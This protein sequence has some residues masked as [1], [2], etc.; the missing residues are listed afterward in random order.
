MKV[1]DM[2]NQIK[3]VLFKEKTPS[4]RPSRRRSKSKIERSTS[5][6][7]PALHL[8][9]HE[10]TP[11]SRLAVAA[12]PLAAGGPT[13]PRSPSQHRGET[14]VKKAKIKKS[15]VKKMEPR[16]R[17]HSKTTTQTI[18]DTLVGRTL[19]GNLCGA[20]LRALVRHLV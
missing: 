11:S 3:N 13:Q 1:N 18:F 4:N 12:A 8:G 15:C 19:F 20:L 10:R 9:H 17:M 14:A 5:I 7:S 16:T 2:L 6:A